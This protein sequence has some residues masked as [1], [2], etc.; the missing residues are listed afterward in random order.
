MHEMKKFQWRALRA[1]QR[2]LDPPMMAS[3]KHSL[4]SGHNKTIPG[5]KEIQQKSRC[6]SSATSSPETCPSP[7]TN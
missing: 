5:M 3:V 2:P 1:S 4:L 7:L 6:P